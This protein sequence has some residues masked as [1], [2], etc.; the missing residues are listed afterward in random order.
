MCAHDLRCT[1]CPL[2]PKGLLRVQLTLDVLMTQAASTGGNYESAMISACKQYGMKP[3]CDH[4]SY[5]KNDKNAIYIGQNHHLAYPH[6]RRESSYVPVRTT[7]H[8]LARERQRAR[9]YIPR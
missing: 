8:L 4:P 9:R 6:H 3:V 7:Q 2:T 5:C 1:R